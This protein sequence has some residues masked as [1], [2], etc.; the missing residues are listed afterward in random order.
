MS[1]RQMYRG[2][3]DACDAVNVIVQ[4]Y[5]PRCGG[6]CTEDKFLCEYCARTMSGNALDYPD[7]YPDRTVLFTICA[8]ANML[9]S[10]V[11]K[12]VADLRSS[13]N[14]TPMDSD[15]TAGIIPRPDDPEE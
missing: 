15:I 1:E 11:A 4:K 12:M 14:L 9:E 10:N 2:R 3:C 8:V 7:Q 5:L 6:R 13:L